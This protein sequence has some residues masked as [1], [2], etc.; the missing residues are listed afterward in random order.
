MITRHRSTSVLAV[1]FVLAW[2]L[3]SGCATRPELSADGFKESTP[4]ATSPAPGPNARPTDPEVMYRVFAGEFLGA[5]GDLEKA[6]DEYL[7]AAVESDDPEIAERATQVAIAAQAWQHAAMAADRWALLQPDSLDAR[8]IAAR[9]MILVGDYANAEH[10]LSGILDLMSHDPARAWSIVAALLTASANLDKADRILQRLVED[11][12]AAGDADALLARSRMAA[13]AGDLQSAAELAGRAIE[14]DPD[15][16][17]IFAWAGRL[18]VNMGDEAHAV[19]LYRSA[20]SLRPGSRQITVAYAELLRRT[21]DA[22]QAQEVLTSLPDSPEV[23]F[24]RVAFAL[25]SGMDEL[26]E[27]I[28]AGFEAAEYPE[29]MEKAFQAAQSAELLGKTDEALAWY[30]QVPSGERALVAAL[31]RAFLLAERGDLQDARNLLAGLRIR[32]DPVVMKESFVAE[33][34]ILLDADQPQGA[35]DLL[36]E[37][38]EIMGNDTQILYSRALIAVQLDRLEIAEQD[39]RK[40][41]EEQ[42]QNAAALNALGYTLADQTDRYAEAESLISAAYA[43]QPEEASIVDS[44]GWIAYRMGRLEEAERYLREAWARDQNAEIAA[45]LGEVLWAAGREDEAQAAWQGGL[46]QDAENP[47]LLETMARFGIEP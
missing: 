21:G 41:I 47:V 36:S 8:E 7:A 4:E 20:W 15:R 27:S 13:R 22:E 24:T 32:R 6:A 42:P 26:A 12:G 37:A 28:Y 16:A 44:M 38:L 43:L 30:K 39:L 33:G 11:R 5:E 2:T 25:E 40:I 18:A 29:P 46:E 35:F 17:E 23:R 19:E 10:Q 31:R 14:L 45:H 34:Q 9:A 3:L 1:C